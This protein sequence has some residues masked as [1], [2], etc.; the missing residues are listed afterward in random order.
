MNLK[1]DA[2]QLRDYK[3]TPE[4]LAKIQRK[5]IYIICDNILD[6][7]NIGAIF[8][9]ADAAAVSGV[10]LVGESGT[11]TDAVTGHKVHKASVGTWQWTPWKHVGT[12]QEALDDIKRELS[13]HDTDDSKSQII[14]HKSQKETLHV[15]RST[16]HV[17]AVEQSE[18]SVPYT[19]AKYDMPLALILGHETTGVSA[20][21]L[22]LADQTVEISMFGVNKSLNVMVSLA[23]V[24]WEILRK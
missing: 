17:V 11:P 3:P 21:G 9:L 16:L 20:E 6:T 19:D 22:S 4:E 15:T 12:I 18:K 24:L 7:Y 23:I 5:P 14:N 13:N 2:S 1:L 10:Y 8:R